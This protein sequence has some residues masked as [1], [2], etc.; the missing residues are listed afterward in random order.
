M[1]IK[2]GENA[3]VFQLQN[4]I[5]YNRGHKR[6]VFNERAEG[7]II[8]QQQQQNKN[9]NER[10]KG[11]KGPKSVERKSLINSRFPIHTQQCLSVSHEENQRL[12][13]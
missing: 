1:S 10:P 7:I 3:G 11:A 2:S 6:V 5:N 4:I 9:K 8:K 12:P 13:C